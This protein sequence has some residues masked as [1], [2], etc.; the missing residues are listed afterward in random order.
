M[1]HQPRA[2]PAQCD[3]GFTL[4]EM[5]VSMLLLAVVS[6]AFYPVVLHSTEAA[7]RGT[8]TST[9]T[10]LMSKQLER[11]R[12]TPLTSCPAVGPEPLGTMVDTVTDARGVQLQAWTKREGT[13]TTGARYVI[14]ITRSSAP[15][16]PLATATT[17]VALEP[18][19]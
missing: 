19:P 17:F 5:I 2:T 16:S 10:R 12:A 4:T 8:T 1:W 13:C 9:A 7:A 18:L 6:L 14:S 11:L 15:S 3:S